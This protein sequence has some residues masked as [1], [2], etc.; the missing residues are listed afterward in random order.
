MTDGMSLDTALKFVEIISILGGGGAVAFRLGR[1]TKSM[2][3]AVER[4]TLILEGHRDDILELKTEIKKLNDVLTA[5][6]VQSGR[7]DRAE[8]SIREMRHGQGFVN[9]L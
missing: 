5:L 8:E 9:P 1:A 2:D 4:Q 3:A 7:L 6:A